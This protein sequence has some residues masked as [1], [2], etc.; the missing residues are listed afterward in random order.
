MAASKSCPTLFL[1]SVEGWKIRGWGFALPASHWFG[2]NRYTFEGFW[3]AASST[4]Q[5]YT[6]FV[7]GTR[8]NTTW[9]LKRRYK[10][11]SNASHAGKLG[12]QTWR[13]GSLWSRLGCTVW[14]QPIRK[15]HIPRRQL[16]WEIRRYGRLGSVKMLSTAGEELSIVLLSLYTTV[17]SGPG[18]GR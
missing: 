1:S 18:L 7:A 11:T 14:L 5:D 17:E 4:E 6:W 8:A 2:I 15:W 10:W 12:R 16:W 3:L 9:D 13:A